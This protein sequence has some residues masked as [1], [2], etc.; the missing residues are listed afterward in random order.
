[1]DAVAADVGGTCGHAFEVILKLAGKDGSVNSGPT[2]EERAGAYSASCSRRL[3]GQRLGVGKEMPCRM[4]QTI[5]IMPPLMLPGARDSENQHKLIRRFIPKGSP[6]GN[7]AVF[8]K[9]SFAD[10]I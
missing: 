2:N 1:M 6:I 3:P 7:I 5:Y 10:W 4:W 9:F 8:T